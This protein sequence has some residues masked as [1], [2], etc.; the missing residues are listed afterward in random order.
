MGATALTR[1]LALA[2]PFL[3]VPVVGASPSESY[4]VPPLLVL[5]AVGIE[6]ATGIDD[7]G[8]TPVLVEGDPGAT[9]SMHVARG[10]QVAALRDALGA[11]GRLVIDAKWGAWLGAGNGVRLEPELTV[12]ANGELAPVLL[13]LN[14]EPTMEA[15]RLVV[16]FSASHVNS[17]VRGHVVLGRD[18][19][20][21]V[22][23][24]PGSA[25]RSICIVVEA[26]NVKWSDDR[27]RVVSPS[28]EVNFDQEPLSDALAT[29]SD[30]AGTQVG[31]EGSG[32][33]VSLHVRAPIDR[34]VGL[35]AA[36]VE[37]VPDL[38]P[39]GL[40]L[41]R[42]MW[43][44]DWGRVIGLVA[45][46]ATFE[47]FSEST[48]IVLVHAADEL[49]VRRVLR[50]LSAWRP[51]TR[52]L[53]QEV[54]GAQERVS[55]QLGPPGGLVARWKL[56]GLAA[57][58]AMEG[59]RKARRRGLTVSLDEGMDEIVLSASD[60]ATLVRAISQ[61]SQMEKLAALGLVPA[62]GP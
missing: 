53:E 61:L 40:G 39:T 29:I 58:N 8:M 49:A 10:R 36:Q 41:V 25:M 15:G 54:D 22:S 17:T 12:A 33:H 7:T 31:A 28:I 34:I 42:A 55:F 62:M 37:L 59:L 60:E 4:R 1:K 48:G 44:R 35:I 21:I 9:A 46:D 2:A 13:N 16:D 24:R 11:D 6:S 27:A 26:T 43:L 32:A 14:A 56:E 30:A 57:A 45:P 38:G 51:E 5:H 23:V 18:E 50:K 20:L 3:L 52:V 19:A 47:A